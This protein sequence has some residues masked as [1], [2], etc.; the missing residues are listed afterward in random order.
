MKKFLL[1]NLDVFAWLAADIPGISPTIITHA[2]NVSPKA[3]PIRQ[4]NRKST[5]NR[6]QVTKKE[7][8]KLLLRAGFIREVQ[9]FDWLSNMVMVKKVSGKW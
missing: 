9:Y 6:I 4:T 2:L 1:K 8:K 5:L 7:I 3:W